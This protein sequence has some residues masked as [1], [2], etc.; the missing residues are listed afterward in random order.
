MTDVKVSMLETETMASVAQETAALI[1]LID[2][3]DENLDAL[4]AEIN[5]LQP[6]HTWVGCSISSGEETAAIFPRLTMPGSLYPGTVEQILHSHLLAEYI[7]LLDPLIYH[8]PLVPQMREK[9]YQF[10]DS[11]LTDRIKYHFMNYVL[12]HPDCNTARTLNLDYVPSDE[13]VLAQLATLPQ[14]YPYICLESGS[15]NQNVPI[16]SR[17]N[18]IEQVRLQYPE[19]QLICSGGISTPEQARQLR[20]VCD[21]VLVSHA[22]HQNPAL[23]ESYMDAIYG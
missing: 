18:L 3:N 8:T 11:G 5:T 1:A 20:D 14:V 4:V 12:L 6:A 10:L 17:M 9:V 23:L 13:V 7:Y 21:Y 19:T 22:I 2:P 16:S 15:R